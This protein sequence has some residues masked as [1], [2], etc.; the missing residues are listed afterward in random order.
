MG[1]VNEGIRRDTEYDARFDAR[2][3][4]SPAYPYDPYYMAIYLRTR[5]ELQRPQP[6][7]PHNTNEKERN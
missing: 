2:F 1:A 4:L 5:E 7:V 3:G 6:Q